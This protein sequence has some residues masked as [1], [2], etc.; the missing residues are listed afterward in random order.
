MGDVL[1]M[2]QTDGLS[3]LL[4]LYQGVA[5][6]LLPQQVGAQIA[7]GAVVTHDTET[8]AIE[9]NDFPRLE[10]IRTLEVEESLHAGHNAVPGKLGQHLHHFNSEDV[11]IGGLAEPGLPEVSLPEFAQHRVTAQSLVA[12]SSINYKVGK[13][14]A[15]ISR[16][17]GQLEPHIS[18]RVLDFLP[19]REVATGED[20]DEVPRG[21][22]LLLHAHYPG[23]ERHLLLVL[24]RFLPLRASGVLQLDAHVVHLEQISLLG[25]PSP[26]DHVPLDEV[27]LLFCGL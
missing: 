20:V 3:Y 6:V 16:D 22:V 15:S 7:L 11:P 1:L 2:Q 25:L 12:H 26:E 21:L 17:A 27:N 23:D 5:E 18:Q 13:R 14:S 10:D 24:N 19:F 9:W 8:V 4:H